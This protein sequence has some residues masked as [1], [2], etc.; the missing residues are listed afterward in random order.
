MSRLD[1]RRQSTWCMCRGRILVAVLQAEGGVSGDG[2][3]ISREADDA[4]RALGQKDGAGQSGTYRTSFVP[5][6]GG[7]PFLQDFEK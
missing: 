6:D 5:G 2:Q 7:K 4:E 1:N 3:A